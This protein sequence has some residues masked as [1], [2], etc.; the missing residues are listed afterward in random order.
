MYWIAGYE[1]AVLIVGFLLNV[2]IPYIP[3]IKQTTHVHILFG[4]GFLLFFNRSCSGFVS[5]RS[6]ATSCGCWGLGLGWSTTSHEEVLEVLAFQGLFENLRPDGLNPDVCSVDELGNLG[7]G[8]LALKALSHL[9][10][11]REG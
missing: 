9:G 1:R 4:L 8:D 10:V 6:G 2:H 7:G 11:R 5:G 3:S